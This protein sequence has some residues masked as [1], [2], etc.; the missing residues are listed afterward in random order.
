M[1]ECSFSSRTVAI[2][3]RDAIVDQQRVYVQQRTEAD[4]ADRQDYT[5][6]ILALDA[7]YLALSLA[8]QRGSRPGVTS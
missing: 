7:A 4:P 2:A 5:D 1:I 8:L 3:A 6:M